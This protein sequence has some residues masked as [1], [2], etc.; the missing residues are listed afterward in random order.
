[1][2]NMKM[3]LFIFSIQASSLA[4]IKWAMGTYTWWRTYRNEIHHARNTASW[5]RHNRPIRSLE[6]D[7]HNI[8]DLKYDVCDFIVEIHKENGQEYPRTSL[9]DLL[10]GLSLYL[11]RERIL[12]TY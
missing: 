2:A 3:H 7:A 8:S 11:Q 10:G 5:N 12:M 6:E 4:K 9:Y 1:M